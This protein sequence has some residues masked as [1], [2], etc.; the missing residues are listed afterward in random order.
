VGPSPGDLIAFA[1]D[2]I[3]EHLV[4]VSDAMESQVAELPAAGSNAR[5]DRHEHRGWV[6]FL[7]ARLNIAF[8]ELGLRCINRGRGGDTSR[9]LLERLER[10]VSVHQPRWCC[11]AVGV[12][13]VRRNFQ[14]ELREQA[15]SVEEYSSNLRR[16]TRHL[17]QAGAGVILLEPI[18]HS[19]PPIGAPP[20][21]SVVDVNYLTA[22]YAGALRQVATECGVEWVELYRP[23]LRLET[24]FSDRTPPQP[25]YADE[26]HLNTLGDMHYAQLVF[27]AL[28]RIWG[29][30]ATTE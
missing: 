16:M 17:R 11:L 29:I 30:E 1:G 5:V 6:E 14:P 18:P 23:F 7:A 22:T 25:M 21:A 10:D 13:D 12:V 4:A 26:I 15:V 28:L 2:S 8:P 24:K 9:L 27:E 20:E 3:V 19:R